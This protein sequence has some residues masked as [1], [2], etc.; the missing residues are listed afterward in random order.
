MSISGAPRPRVLVA[1][2]PRFRERLFTPSAWQRLLNLA[3]VTVSP[4]GGA[5]DTPLAYE[6]LHDADIVLTG[7][8]TYAQS[9]D[10]V[11][12]APGLRAIV[13]AAGTVR[14]LVDE[15]V[16][17]RG[18]AVS[19]QAEQNG[20]P[21]AE[22]SLAMILLSAKAV[23]RAEREYRAARAGFPIDSLTGGAFGARIGIVGA[24]KIG[25]R[26]LGLLRPF[27]F[28]VRVY[29]PYLD[30]DDAALLGVT[31]AGLDDL[32]AACDVVSLH[33]PHL[34]ETEGMIG[35]AQLRRLR[36]GAVFINTA[37]GAL[38]D[39]DALVAELQTGRIDAVLDVTEPDVLPVESPLW[40]LPN[41]VL[42]PHLAGSVGNE[43]PRLGTEAI[44]EVARLAAGEPLRHPLTAQ[45][46]AITA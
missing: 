20:R 3:D 5:L 39:Q 11:E 33:A 40:D 19:S 42:T 12:H 45:Q 34:P 6:R 32:F 38:V 15:R 10:W 7:W 37:R 2:P 9:G 26:L 25:R 24:S 36:D 46:F 4:A 41:V 31:T 18:I 43:V 29:D 22:Y 8:G 23:F 28:D 44:A 27:D 21:V 13:H 16:F 30:A 1:I 35:A 17:A 14:F